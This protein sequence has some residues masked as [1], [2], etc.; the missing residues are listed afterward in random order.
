[1]KNYSTEVL[2][3]VHSGTQVHEPGCLVSHIDD[4]ESIGTTIS[5]HQSQNWSYS[6]HDKMICV[7]WSKEPDVSL[8]RAIKSHVQNSLLSMIYSPIDKTFEQ[9]CVNNITQV[10]EVF[11]IKGQILDYSTDVYKD[12][13]TQKMKVEIKYS[14]LA[15]PAVTMIL[16]F[17]F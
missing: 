4:S 3:P 13:N 6:G 7:L 10:L 14:K 2:R 15:A 8:E 11:R 17:E 1:M 12:Y 16:T 5:S 9:L